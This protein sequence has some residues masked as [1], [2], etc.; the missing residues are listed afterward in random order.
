MAELGVD[1]QN[2]EEKCKQWFYEV[3]GQYTRLR[4]QY[5]PLLAVLNVP[6]AEYLHNNK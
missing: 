2:G 6:Q 5:T 4:D 3:R 1:K